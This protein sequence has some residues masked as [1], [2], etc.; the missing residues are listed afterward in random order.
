MSNY[1]LVLSDEL[2]SVLFE[3]KK[4][5]IQNPQLVERFLSYYHSN[6]LTN[7]AQLIRINQADPSLLQLLS[8]SGYVSQNLDE[9]V[10]ETRY[11]IILN[12]TNSNYPYV[13][14]NNDKIEKN[15]SLTFKTNENRKKAIEIIKALCAE[16]K[17]I[18]IVD[19]YFFENINW[20]DT[21]KIFHEILPKNPLK[22]SFTNG[23]LK[24]VHIAEI[25]KIYPHWKIPPSNNSKDSH[26]RYLIIDDKIEIILSS[27]FSYLFAT[28]KDLTLLIREK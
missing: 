13:N 25:K 15:F 16:A 9:L 24:Q 21:K 18:L 27:G 4:G 22:L 17:S 5:Q 10:K 8:A 2:L 28:D 11:K 12:T 6:Y 7:T 20:K 26:D 19:K 1:S 14:I 23:K 3:F